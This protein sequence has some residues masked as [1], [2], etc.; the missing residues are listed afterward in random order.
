MAS[1]HIAGLAA[2][3]AA[4]DGVRAGP[5]LCSKIVQTATPNRIRNPAPNTVNLI[6]FNGNPSG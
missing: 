5:G 2:Y 4:R 1:P 6:A 3:I